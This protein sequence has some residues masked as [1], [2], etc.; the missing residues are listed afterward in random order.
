MPEH[1]AK[2]SLTNLGKR[3]QVERSNKMIFVWVLGAAVIVTLC[4]V[5]GTF[6]VRQGLFNAKIIGEKS[7][8]EKILATN[9]TNANEL[10][11]NVDK[12][13]ADSNLSSI[14][15]SPEDNAVQVIFDALPTA[16]DTTSLSNSL[17]AS[18][19][20]RSG[21][22]I[23]SVSAGDTQGA[24]AIDGDT[25]VSSESSNATTSIPIS[26]TT[27]GSIP[28][29]LAMLKDTERSIMPISPTN[30]MLRASGNGSLDVLFSGNTYYL[31]PVKIKLGSKPVRP[32]L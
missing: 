1:P 11:G 23:K 14:K 21:V 32:D 25:A 13:L 20:V 31:A 8:T 26:F 18:I 3:Q 24:I 9:I 15:A 29:T 7:K 27:T 4:V 10:K 2:T 12:L 30:I 28:A 22:G 17:Y 6:L 16:A 5:L 19:L